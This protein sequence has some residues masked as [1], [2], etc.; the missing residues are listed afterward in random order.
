MKEFLPLWRSLLWRRARGSKGFK[1]PV[2][3]RFHWLPY[4]IR[5]NLIRERNIRAFCPL[6]CL[7]SLYI[8]QFLRGQG[9]IASVTSNLSLRGMT[10]RQKTLI[11]IS[12]TL[13]CLLMSLYLSLSTIWL[14]GF[15]QIELHQT[16][17]N[18][19]QVTEALA[20][21]LEQLNTT[22]K[23]WAR[24]DESYAFVE[25]VN[26]RYVQA[27]LGDQS[28]ANLRLNILLF[29]NNAGQIAYGK[30]LDLQQK[31]EVPV[32]D[33]LRQ[34]L[35]THP[36]L[37]QHE[38]A[39]SSHTGIVLL[40]EG[41]LL[42][43]CQ[44][45]V[46]SDRTS[47]IRGT[48]LMGRFL[49]TA[50]VNRFSELTHLS[51]TVYPFQDALLPKDFQSV[52]KKLIEEL[53]N[54]ET[55]DSL[56]L[57]LPLNAESIAGYTLLRDIERQ[58]GLLLRVNTSRDIY[59]QGK[60]GLGYLVGVLLSVGLAF[61]IATQLLLE[62]SVVLPISR[63]NYFV[64]NIR[65]SGDLSERLLTGGRDELS[66]LGS[67]INELLAKS[68]QSQLLLSQSEERYR[69]VV[70]NVT[71]VIFQTNTSGMWTFLNP[72][73]TEITGFSIE[74]SLGMPCWKFI[75][76]EDQPY[77]DQQFSRLIKGEI[78]DTRYEIRYQTQN[79]SYR[80]FEVHS[81]FTVMSCDALTKSAVGIVGTAGTLN[82]ITERKRAEAR[83]RAKAQELEQTLRELRRTQTQL[84]QS[85]KMSSLGQLVAGIA[86]E[87]NN[88][89]T[90]VSGNL[91]HA[92]QYTQYLLHLID[93]YQQ[94]YPNPPLAIKQEM[95][96]I[97]F[98]FLVDDLPHL[99]NS[100]K[101]GAERICEIVLSL[102]NFS[103]LDEA[104]IKAVD[105]H[106]GIDS[107]LLILEHR[108]K[109]QGKQSEIH[110]LKE[111]G[112]LPQVECYPGQLNQVFMNL[113]SNAIDALEEKRVV[114]E[115]KIST[116]SPHI[117]IRTELKE[118]KPLR[119]NSSAVPNDPTPLTRILIRIADNGSGMTEAV[120][121]R[122]FDPF[123]TTKSTGKGT[124]L[125]LSISY[126][127]VVEKHKGQL[128]VKSKLGR[129]T[130]FIIELPLQQSHPFG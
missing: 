123:F 92:S 98:E 126:R 83:E 129:G 108:L 15:A 8:H 46:K 40:P 112:N 42:V 60:K 12:M 107:T 21:D 122:L 27:N 73:W 24:W 23:D 74:E 89:I 81:R 5:H 77:H 114:G 130:E 82:D 110:I 64:K 10:L 41:P 48:L 116:A 18:I 87:I 105:L 63:F 70:N 124:G 44:P 28:L 96:A 78:Q 97:D 72:A 117:R 71:E 25:D 128:L 20:N 16:Y 95:E 31:A 62:K 61:G 53:P 49:N 67:A 1:P 58:P 35:T 99:L 59:Q 50:Q 115:S 113:L 54:T 86:H 52:R 55:Q 9:A 106:E 100:M 118:D 69:S 120:H 65:A 76:P 32:P 80:W 93:S 88:P 90:F 109:A 66:R 104:E 30:G 84:I 13:L 19:E 11:I 36:R 6:P 57:A 102:R 125:G 26:E 38:G 91:E 103:R 79:G 75:H 17:Q 34:Y 68:Q 33:S 43:A 121:H 37:L 14:N 119:G 4:R 22:A 127:I 51:L 3:Q 39:D 7:Q 101:V 2:R 47:P 56:I 85:E 29:I 111:Y 94:H 45:I